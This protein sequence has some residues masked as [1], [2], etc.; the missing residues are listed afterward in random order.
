GNHTLQFKIKSIDAQ[1]NYAIVTNSI[2]TSTLPTI[3]APTIPILSYNINKT[4]NGTTDY[5]D[6]INDLPK[7]KS[8]SEGAIVIKFKTTSTIPN[9]VLFSLSDNTNTNTALSILLGATS[10]NLS[11]EV[12]KNGL[13]LASYNTP[14]I[15]NDGNVHT[16]LIN[17]G[18]RGTSIYIDGINVFSLPS[19]KIFFSNISNITTMNI[20]R[21]LDNTLSGKGYFNG[22]I[23]YID[24]YSK[25]L[26]VN[27]CIIYSLNAYKATILLPKNTYNLLAS[28]LAGGATIDSRNN[29]TGYIGGIN[30]GTANLTINSLTTSLYNLSIQYL[31]GDIGVKRPLK[32]DITLANSTTIVSPSPTLDW[33]LSNAKSFSLP[34]I[35]NMGGNS[36][37]FHGNG[38]N[39]APSIGLV[40]LTLT[41]AI[42]TLS[43][44]TVPIYYS[45]N[46]I[47]GSFANGAIADTTLNIAGWIGGPS[48]GSLTLTATVPY[49]GVYNLNFKYISG[50]IR[51]LKINTKS[52][53]IYNVAATNDW[54]PKNAKSFTLPVIFSS[55][56]NEIKFQGDG[57]NYAPSI[58]L[59]SI[60]SITTPTNI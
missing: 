44:P 22:T 60:K 48:D 2:N 52:S 30:K 5:L 17:V 8:L 23:E 15:V 19:S 16:S 6:L 39:Y 21:T 59:I 34:I 35:L 46:P 18:S 56:N 45:F 7:V 10:K 14:T 50:E 36:I 26:L 33:T 25:E 54:F 58:G 57:I 24:I 9:K 49:S 20:G 41:K 42:S 55:G 3:T 43:T 51:P 31:S 28:T 32:I 11:Y 1:I 29:F 47:K 27:Q 40:T 13:S 53:F 4:F 37:Q 38:T 12:T